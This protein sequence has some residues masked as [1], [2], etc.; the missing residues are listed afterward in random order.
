MLQIIIIILNGLFEEPKYLSKKENYRISLIEWNKLSHTVHWQN[1]KINTHGN[2]F[3]NTDI[4]Y[5]IY[6][7]CL[8]QKHLISDKK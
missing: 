3:I 1:V 7:I 5:N 2:I 8:A 4:F 6:L